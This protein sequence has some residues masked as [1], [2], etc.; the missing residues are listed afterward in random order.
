MAGDTPV[1]RDGARS[2][3]RFDDVYE[4]HFKFVWKA[5]R[6][7]GVPEA[8]LD[9]VV[10]EVFVVVHR[11]LHE[12]NVT[13]VRSWL[14]AIV[15]HAARNH[16]R[17][18]RGGH[19]EIAQSG[20]EQDVETMAVHPSLPPDESAARDE[21]L[22]VLEKILSTLDEEKLEVF[23]MAEIEQLT[24]PQIAELLGINVNTAY[25]RLRA[26]RQEFNEGVARHRARDSW[27]SR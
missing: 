26:A 17:G 11:K 22:R 8:S 7:L 18:S 19:R 21:G 2:G 14:Y 12:Q 27:K 16:R 10:Q 3:L 24:V 20:T 23:V 5:A 25:A 13:S 6:R 15:L 4:A 1:E 9:D